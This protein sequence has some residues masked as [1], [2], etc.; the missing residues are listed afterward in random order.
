VGTLAAAQLFLWG[1]HEVAIG[2]G[3]SASFVGVTIVAIGTSL[4]ELVTVVQ[5]AR[6]RQGDLILG[7]LLGSNI[8]NALMVA[9]LSGAVGSGPLDAP[10]LTG[11]ATSAMLVQTAAVWLIMRTGRRISRL[12]GI[13]LLLSYGCLV[14]FLATPT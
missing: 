10:R 9:G 6:R 14:P 3:L 5:S 4:P 8:F 1:A 2:A 7:N 11:L 12:E 13:L